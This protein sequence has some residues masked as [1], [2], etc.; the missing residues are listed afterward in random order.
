MGDEFPGSDKKI[1]DI[2]YS[3]HCFAVIVISIYIVT[4]NFLLVC[5]CV[6][7]LNS[8]FWSCF[9]VIRHDHVLK[10]ARSAVSSLEFLISE[11][12]THLVF[13]P[14]CMS[15]HI[16]IE[17]AR[18]NSNNWLADIWWIPVIV[19]VHNSFLPKYNWWS[20]S[21][22]FSNFLSRKNL[23]HFRKMGRVFHWL[24]FADKYLLELEEYIQVLTN[25]FLSDD[26][27]WTSFCMVSRGGTTSL[28]LYH[29]E[30]SLNVV[31]SGFCKISCNYL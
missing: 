17:L 19:F 3:K 26:K 18:I 11:S 15:W 23:D 7:A 30:K 25:Q 27:N 9:L 22:I 29:C 10:I 2:P 8:A 4:V 16:G 1:N 31:I 5:R 14:V 13:N 20:T 21:H 6:E 12:N 28:L 24:I